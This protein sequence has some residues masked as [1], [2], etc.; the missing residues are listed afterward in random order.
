MSQDDLGPSKA[1]DIPVSFLDPRLFM[2]LE[3]IRSLSLEAANQCVER[4][5]SVEVRPRVGTHPRLSDARARHSANA[6]QVP[7][8]GVLSTPQAKGWPE[9]RD[10]E[11]DEKGVQEVQDSQNMVASLGLQQRNEAVWGWGQEATQGLRADILGIRWRRAS[12]GARLLDLEPHQS[13]RRVRGSL[14]VDWK[15]GGLGADAVRAATHWSKTR[16]SE[17]RE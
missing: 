5:P 1:W 10:P 13:G 9:D 11:P 6:Q 16:A 4:T 7:Q 12:E 8:V 14:A 3:G 17:S 2:P 15:T